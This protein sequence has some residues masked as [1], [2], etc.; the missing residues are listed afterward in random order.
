MQPAA[1]VRDGSIAVLDEEHHLVVPV[2]AAERPPVVKDQRLSVLGPPVLVEDL[3]AVSSADEWHG[4]AFLWRM[5]ASGTGAVFVGAE[6]ERDRPVVT[7]RTQ[8]ETTARAS[9]FASKSKC[10]DSIERHVSG[11]HDLDRSAIER[12]PKRAVMLE[13][14]EAEKRAKAIIKG[15][16]WKGPHFLISAMKSEG[17]RDLVFA[18]MDH[19][20]AARAEAAKVAASKEN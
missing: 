17:C 18:I 7:P 19:L 8:V 16:K 2:V 14:A 1:V 9:G 5:P 11:A 13:P 20:D 6:V 4:H 15:L 10:S 12:E 3:R